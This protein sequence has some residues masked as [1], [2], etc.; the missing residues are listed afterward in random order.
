M[1]LALS[2]PSKW[3]K[4]GQKGVG[5]V[6]EFVDIVCDQS[7]TDVLNDD[8]YAVRLCGGFVQNDER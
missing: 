6:Q 7:G 3:V 5:E 1:T 8:Q 4:L 2:S